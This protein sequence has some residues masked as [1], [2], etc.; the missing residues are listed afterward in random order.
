M[1][2]RRL[3]AWRWAVSWKISAEF[4]PSTKQSAI[5]VVAEKSDL[6]I[7]GS[8]GFDQ[9]VSSASL[10]IYVVL[11]GYTTRDPIAQHVHNLCGMRRGS[12]LK[13]ANFSSCLDNMVPD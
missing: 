7:D 2:G 12:E 6:Q 13:T 9:D 5:G 10:A 11:I 1:N 3:S 8:H 4:P